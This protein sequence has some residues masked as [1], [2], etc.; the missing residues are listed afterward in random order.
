MKKK[1]LQELAIEALQTQIRSILS[2]DFDYDNPGPLY[3][4][5]SND[6]II[7]LVLKILEIDP[8]YTNFT[9]HQDFI[10]TLRESK[11]KK[12]LELANK[13]S[14]LPPASWKMK[15]GET[16]LIQDMKDS[17]LVNTLKMLERTYFIC[18]LI[19]KHPVYSNLYH[20]AKKRGLDGY[21]LSIEE[22]AEWSYENDD[23][24]SW[25]F[26]PDRDW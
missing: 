14:P 19:D 24:E 16:I 9:K 8:N 18:E 2:P 26:D 13:L 21:T 10:P 15:T 6:A 11:N 12:C 5:A 23:D 20:E 25:F 7:P 17:H 1:E 4:C 3:S 22:H